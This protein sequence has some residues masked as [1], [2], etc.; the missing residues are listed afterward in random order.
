MS[1]IH[2]FMELSDSVQNSSWGGVYL[3]SSERFV[4]DK[5]L[6]HGDVSI[7]PST[8]K[9]LRSALSRSPQRP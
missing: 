3:D 5:I 9:A 8:V 1:I 2:E 7:N 6:S 4:V